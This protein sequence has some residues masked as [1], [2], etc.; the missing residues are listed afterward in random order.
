MRVRWKKL[1]AKT[2]IWLAIEICLNV[3]GLDT[4]ADYSEFIYLRQAFN[5]ISLFGGI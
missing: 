3:L 2:L 4:L 5:T 1:L